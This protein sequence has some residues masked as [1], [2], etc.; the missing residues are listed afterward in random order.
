MKE[1]RENLEIN[2]QIITGVWRTFKWEI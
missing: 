1:M 2:H